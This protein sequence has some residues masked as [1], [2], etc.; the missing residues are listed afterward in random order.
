MAAAFSGRRPAP[1]VFVTGG[2][3]SGKSAYAEAVAAKLAPRRLYIATAHACDTEM[4]ER[5]RLHQE[6]RGPGWRVYE[7][8]P[9]HAPFLAEALA[10]VIRPDEAV[11][12][13]CLSLWAAD[14]MRDGAMPENFSELCDNLLDTLW[15]LPCP[16]IVVSCEVG[17]GVVP[18]H[19]AGRAFRDM[20][21]IAAQ[22]AAAKALAAVLLVSGI[23]VFIKGKPPLS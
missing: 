20:A 11:L 19:P 14:C 1:F 23:P 8:T 17:M 9:G 6:A 4:R 16:I 18:E 15:A 3:R 2:C 12:L 21:G 7:P 10:A 5:I 22:K 13:D